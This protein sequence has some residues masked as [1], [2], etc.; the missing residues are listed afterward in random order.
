MSKHLQRDLD[1]FL[2]PV[3]AANHI[4][5]VNAS[6]LHM[7]MLTPAGPPAGRVRAEGASPP[8]DPVA[9]VGEQQ[10]QVA[11][12]THAVLPRGPRPSWARIRL[13]AEGM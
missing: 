5:L 13:L 11:S 1:R 10:P 12:R 8:A 7:G 6:P 9:R 3:A 2:T 4:A